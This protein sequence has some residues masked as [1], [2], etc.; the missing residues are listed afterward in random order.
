[1]KIVL[2]REDIEEAV[3][4]YIKDKYL[5]YGDTRELNIVQGSKASAVVTFVQEN[6]LPGLDKVETEDIE[7]DD[8]PHTTAATVASD[9]PEPEKAPF[10]DEP[11]R[12]A[13]PEPKPIG[14]KAP[15]FP[16]A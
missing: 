4:A 11:E 12:E 1:M 5:P 9:E 6:K 2:N 16:K 10:D 8:I 14:M 3:E 7:E 13:P 15:T